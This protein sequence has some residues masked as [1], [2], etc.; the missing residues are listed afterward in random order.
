[1]TELLS[2]VE[3]I[4]IMYVPTIMSV[5]TVLV[6]IFTTLKKLKAIDVKKE[7]ET[8]VAPSKKAL[9][10]AVVTNRQLLL[11]NGKLR[12]KLDELITQYSKVEAKYDKSKNKE[13]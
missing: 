13:V 12:Q 8:A 7:V 3:S 1:M 10:E 4:I 2:N 6:N 11:E 5:A 9:D